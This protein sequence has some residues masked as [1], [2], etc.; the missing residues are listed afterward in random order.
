MNEHENEEYIKVVD[1]ESTFNNN[2]LSRKPQSHVLTHFGYLNNEK[3]RKGVFSKI[4][5]F[6]KFL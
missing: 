2:I 6:F 3:T 4:L 1:S 5:N